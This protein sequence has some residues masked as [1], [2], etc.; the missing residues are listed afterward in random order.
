M[1]TKTFGI[2]QHLFFALLTPFDRKSWF[3]KNTSKASTD[4]IY[5]GTTTQGSNGYKNVVERKMY[6]VNTFDPTL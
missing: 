1:Q 4:L 5:L 6:V 2:L 3:L